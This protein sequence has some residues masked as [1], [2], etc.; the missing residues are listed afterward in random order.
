MTTIEN[1]VREYLA[2]FETRDVENILHFFAE[3]AT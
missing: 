3:D 2:A 1:T